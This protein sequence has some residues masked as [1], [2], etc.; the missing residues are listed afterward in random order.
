M[1]LIGQRILIVEDDGFVAA[2]A[3][4]TLQNAGADVIAAPRVTEAINVATCA[5]L[6][7][8]VIDINLGGGAECTPVCKILDQRKVPFAFCTGYQH[9][10]VMDRWPQAPVLHKPVTPDDLLDCV[11]GL[12]RPLQPA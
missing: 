1:R 5:D 3:I 11:A 9:S 8:A 6:S 12:A 2:D 10:H 7:A 4:A